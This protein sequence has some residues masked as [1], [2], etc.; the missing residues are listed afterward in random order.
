MNNEWPILFQILSVQG[1]IPHYLCI[2]DGLIYDSNSNI[3]LLKSMDNLD[4]CTWL[5]VGGLND[6]FASTSMVYQLVPVNMRLKRKP[7]WNLLLPKREGWEFYTK[8][9]C[10]KYKIEK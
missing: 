1:S 7:K 5:H 8:R 9:Q 2:C 3:T 10:V 4:L 6:K